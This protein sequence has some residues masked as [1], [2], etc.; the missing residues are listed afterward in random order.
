[1]DMYLLLPVSFPYPK[2]KAVK[3]NFDGFFSIAK[4]KKERERN[5]GTRD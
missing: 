2:K 4:K 3:D 5:N 1:M